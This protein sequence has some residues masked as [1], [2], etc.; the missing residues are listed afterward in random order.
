M[1]NYKWFATGMGALL[2]LTIGGAMF[3]YSGVSADTGLDNGIVSA[4][5]DRTTQQGDGPREGGGRGNRNGGRNNNSEFLAAELG[6]SEDEL[7]TAR[8]AARDAAPEGAT[9]EERAELLAAELGISVEALQAANEA[10]R[11][12]AIAEAL[13]NGDITQEKIDTKEAM[14]AFKAVFDKKEAMASALGL[15]VEDLEAAKEAG[16]SKE[17]LLEDAGITQEELKAAVDEAKSEALADAVANG[18]LTA[19]QAEL[20]E[21]AP[22][23]GGRGNGGQGGGRNGGQGNRAGGTNQQ[24]A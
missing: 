4:L 22:E 23:R 1:K 21:N 5:V 11:D 13:A 14:E 2:A 16:T 12:A 20:I 15:T 7:T 8:D 3:S 10:A 19:E 24:D 9:R 17:Q 6:I 18:D